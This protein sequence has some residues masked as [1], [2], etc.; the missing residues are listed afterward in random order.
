MTASTFF[1]L[2]V[3]G[4]AALLFVP[5]SR[6]IY[7]LSVRRFE[8]RTDGPLSTRE[9]HGQRVRARLLGL[10]LVIVFSILFNLVTL[11]VP[12]GR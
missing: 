8:R 4:L 3:V 10:F 9:L 11:G 2:S 6:L 1:T 12:V 7:G 5:V